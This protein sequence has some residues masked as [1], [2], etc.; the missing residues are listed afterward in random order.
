MGAA[1]A[2]ERRPG[3]LMSAVGAHVQIRFAELLAP[4]GL[5]PQ[6]FGVLRRLTTNEGSTQQEM[7][8]ALHVRRAA[9]VGLVDE[10]EAKG[11]IERRRH[12]LD[13]RANALHLTTAGRRLVARI[14]T[15]AEGLEAEL[16]GRL[17]DDARTAFLEGLLAVAGVAGVADGIYP[18]PVD[19]QPRPDPPSARAA[20][21]RRA[22]TE[23]KD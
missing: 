23:S 11:F 5:L 18:Q 14:S 1:S 13:R 8:D 2:W 4:Y 10:L 7:A 21:A 3:Y 16:M 12:P 17:S 15:A 22:R 19:E 20:Q 6:H 9:M